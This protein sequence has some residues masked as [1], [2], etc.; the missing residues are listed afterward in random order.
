MHTS[1][2]TLAV[3]V[4]IAAPVPKE[5][6]KDLYFPV[7]AGAVWVLEAQVL[8][9]TVQRTET[10]TK[11]VETDG[12]YRV[13]VEREWGG[14]TIPTVFEVSAKGL[15]QVIPD[16]KELEPLLKFPAKA[17]DKWTFERPG[18]T[19]E[20]RKATHTVGRA[21]EFEVPSGKY[22]AVAVTRV[23]DLGSG[24]PERTTTWY[25]AGVGPVKFV[26]E[27]GGREATY[28]LKSFTPG[29]GEPK[30]EK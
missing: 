5:K 16:S 11:V 9:R 29:K 1:L 3:A 4:T 19:A 12:T 14:Q 21:E 28:E 7:T 23:V 22:K 20:V 25:A 26:S 17:G 6:E 24:R 30:K 27:F 2:L 8:A 18:I 10:V 15:F 13:T